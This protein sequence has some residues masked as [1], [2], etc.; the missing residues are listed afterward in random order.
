[1]SDELDREHRA[2]QQHEEYVA[3]LA[4]E[5]RQLERAREEAQLEEAQARVSCPLCSSPGASGPVH[6]AC[7]DREQAL[8]EE[9]GR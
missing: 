6:P 3:K 2:I 8:A 9:V 4:D 1:M 7:A 5:E